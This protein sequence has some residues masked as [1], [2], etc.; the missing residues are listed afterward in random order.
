MNAMSS[1][2]SYAHGDS[3]NQAFEVDIG[4]EK[5]VAPLKEAIVL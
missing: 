4:I 5:S 3:S 1:L 2:N